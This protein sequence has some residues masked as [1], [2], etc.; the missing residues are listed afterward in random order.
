MKTCI[1]MAAFA[2]LAGC[3]GMGMHTSGG[4]D[5]TSTSSSGYGTDTAEHDRIFNSW[6]N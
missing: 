5:S 3:G 2:L 1:V 6:V 4:M